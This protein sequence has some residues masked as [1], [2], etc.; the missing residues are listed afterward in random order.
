MISFT[1][2]IGKKRSRFEKVTSENLRVWKL[3]VTLPNSNF[4]ELFVMIFDSG[5]MRNNNLF[6]EGIYQKKQKGK[7]NAPLL[8]LCKIGSN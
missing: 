8:I 3:S 7:Q 4:Q 2:S 1:L 6:S 5:L